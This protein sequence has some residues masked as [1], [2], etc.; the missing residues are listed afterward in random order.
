[1]PTTFDSSRRKRNKQNNGSVTSLSILAI[2][3]SSIRLSIWST[4]LELGN[5][6]DVAKWKELLDNQTIPS[7]VYR[8]FQQSTLGGNHGMTFVLT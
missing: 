6:H 8:G 2:I 7:H 5:I 1:M 3:L 4:I